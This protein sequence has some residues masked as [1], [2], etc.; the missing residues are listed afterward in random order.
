[1]LLNFKVKNYKSFVEEAELSML[2]AP[3]QKGL[4]YSLMSGE[5]GRKKFKALSSAV[6]Y[7]PNA[8]GKTNIIGAM[9]VLKSIVLRGN[10][11]NPENSTSPNAALS[12]LELIPNCYT[13]LEPVSFYIDFY[14]TDA[15]D[16]AYRIQ[17]ELEA[18]FGAFMDDEYLRKI[19]DERL[20][21]NEQ[22]V[23]RRSEEHI[24]EINVGPIKKYFSGAN[25]NRLSEL[26]EIAETGFSRDELFLTNGFKLIFSPSFAKLI[27]E[28]FANKFTIIYRADSI[29][30]VRLLASSDKGKLYVDSAVKEAAEIFGVNS[31][32]LGYMENEDKDK[33]KGKGKGG[34]SLYSVI[35]TD[36][37]GEYGVI[38]AEDF[39]SYGTVR[40][41]NLFP[42]ISRALKNGETLVIDEF[43]AS[44]HP[45]ALMN[46]V[47]IFHNDEVN[48]HHAQLI[49]NTHNPV[50]LNS[51][52]YRRDEIKFVERDDETH[53]SVMYSLAD[54]G[55]SGDKGV[56]KGEDYMNGYFVNRY[57]AIKDIDF[58]P[59]FKE[60][61]GINKEEQL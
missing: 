56:R 40:F 28:W 6:I 54:F 50:F 26:K 17:Y 29:H 57:G 38:K 4:D 39:E 16:Q 2:A 42:L 24:E 7:G 58:T 5:V 34:A 18:V 14:V 15:D 41:V 35:K 32:L 47:N 22:L 13:G 36:E 59:L 25:A 19:L 52:I 49:F 37:S 46:I 44:I 1:M 8:S 23:F 33:D 30:A 43:D 55:T 10:I 27:L 53:Q 45:V 11:L 20:T 48:I 61:L 12:N 31:N 51:N 9:E 60:M 3:K 21:V